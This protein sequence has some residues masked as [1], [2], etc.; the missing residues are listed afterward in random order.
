M[1]CLDAGSALAKWNNGMIDKTDI[2]IQAIKEA[3]RFLAEVLTE[4]DLMTLFHDR[5]AAEI[6]RIIEAC[7]DGFQDAM[8]RQADAVRNVPF[9]DTIPF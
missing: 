1:R 9:N 3:R 2:E 6:D 7:I 5:S 4:M 8:Q